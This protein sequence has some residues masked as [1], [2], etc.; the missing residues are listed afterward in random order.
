MAENAER[1]AEILRRLQDKR[2]FEVAREMGVS[3]ATVGGVLRRERNRRPSN[4]ATP[5]FWPY[6]AMVDAWPDPPW[7]VEESRAVMQDIMKMQPSGTIP[8]E[9]R[10]TQPSRPL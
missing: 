1:N 8:S 4:E 2:P 7:T 6:W 10:Q 3:Y 5:D 9:P